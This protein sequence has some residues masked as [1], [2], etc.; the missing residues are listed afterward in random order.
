MSLRESTELRN[1]PGVER[2]QDG[3][4][5]IALLRRTR[6]VER[7]L[8]TAGRPA[9]RVF[10]Y[11]TSRRSRRPELRALPLSVVG[12][13]DR[14]RRER[15]L[16]AP[17]EGGVERRNLTHQYVHGPAVGGDVVQRQ[18]YGVVARGEAHDA[19]AQHQVAAEVE[20][21]G[22]LLLREALEGRS[23]DR[24]PAGWRN[25][26]RRDDRVRRLD[27]LD[28]AV[29]VSDVARAQ[30]LVPRHDGIEGGLQRGAR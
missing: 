27:L 11:E 17:R 10:Q 4:G 26:C 24:L 5:F 23:R 14:Q 7:R 15:A 28:G 12:V 9:S 29:A 20:R 1:E 25:R 8:C 18:E 16:L 30:H 21:T 13:L 6:L 3:A 2:A 22:G 19:D